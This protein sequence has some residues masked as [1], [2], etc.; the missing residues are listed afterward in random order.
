MD[1]KTRRVTYMTGANSTLRT[2][3]MNEEKKK[4][5]KGLPQRLKMVFALLALA[6]ILALV[7]SYALTGSGRDTVGR[8]T[9]IGATLSQNIMPFGDSVI[10]YDGTTLHC[11]AATGGNEWSYQIG[12]NADY[13]ATQER[14]VAWSGNDLYILNSR[15]RLIYNNKMSDTIQFASAGSEYVAVFVGDADNGV[16]SVINSSGQ[17]VDNVTISNQTLLDIGFFKAVTSSSTQ[18]TELMWVLGLD[19]TGTVIS[20]ELQTFQPGKLS[21]GKSSLGEHIAYMIYDMNGALEVVNTRQIMHYNYRVLE[22]SNPTLIY[23]YTVE[24]VK[25]NNNITYQLL[26]PAQET[27]EGISINNV[28]LMYGSVDRVL[29]LPSACIA[30]SLGTHSVYGFGQ[31]AVYVCPFGQT[32]FTAHA[33]PIHVTAMLGMISDNRAVVASG[34]EIYVVELPR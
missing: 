21:T 10:F 5:K 20:T 6:V 29:H 31:N 32:T 7:I 17:I 16:V 3:G 1:R 4:K 27:N 9:R 15:G 2:Y 18:E 14:I 33:L 25:R 13:D 28:R 22:E 12:T 8:V 26:I 24:E 19:T 30:A 34:S 23:G 11:V